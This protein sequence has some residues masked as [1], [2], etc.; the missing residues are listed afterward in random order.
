LARENGR[1][2]F[3]GEKIGFQKKTF[4]PIKNHSFF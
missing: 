2:F 4:L 1:K 3:L